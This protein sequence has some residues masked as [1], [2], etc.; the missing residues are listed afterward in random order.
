LILV[1]E[2]PDFI[3]D[4]GR[5]I[6]YN[7]TEYTEFVTIGGDGT[8]SQLLNG[9]MK[10]PNCDDLMKMPLGI[11]P[12]VSFNAMACSLHGKVENH[13]S[14]NILRG[15]TTPHDLIQ[16]HLHNLNVTKICQ[17][18]FWGFACDLIS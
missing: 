12:G 8:L 17:A 15:T 13:A 11:L 2:Y 9:F 18:I 10:N 16:T 5:E 3:E 7:T 4:W 14:T 6:D 1:T